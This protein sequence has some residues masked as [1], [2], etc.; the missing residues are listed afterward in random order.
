MY[1]IEYNRSKLS[2]SNPIIVNKILDLDKVDSA[3]IACN[4]HNVLLY[5]TYR[6]KS[7]I[8]IYDKQFR[9]E[10]LIDSLTNKQLPVD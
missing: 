3:R 7:S 10:K 4:E 9:Q 5:T 6:Q 2:P 1:I 8:Q